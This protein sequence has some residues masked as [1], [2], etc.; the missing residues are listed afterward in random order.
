M[1]FKGMDGHE[2]SKTKSI[3][4]RRR[5]LHKNKEKIKKITVNSLFNPK[6][7][8]LHKSARSITHGF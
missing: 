7:Y 8:N 4:F 1:C 3:S 2:N 5:D 6:N